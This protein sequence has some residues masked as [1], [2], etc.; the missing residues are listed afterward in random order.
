MPLAVSD[1]TDSFPELARA[2]NAL[3]AVKLE[4]AEAATAQDFASDTG[5][6]DL[7]VKYETAHLVAMSPS[8]EFARL[9]PN[10]EPD[11]ARS[12]YERQLKQ[13]IQGNYVPIVV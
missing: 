7:V 12:I 3:I 13:F 2:G 4:E 6:R 11:G 10:K 5:L 9:D 8:G 1:I